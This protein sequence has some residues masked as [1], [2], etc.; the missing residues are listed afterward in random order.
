MNLSFGVGTSQ[1]RVMSFYFYAQCSGAASR[2]HRWTEGLPELFSDLDSVWIS[3][4]ARKGYILVIIQEPLPEARARYNPTLMAI[5]SF[6]L[7]S[8]SPRA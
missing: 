5:G 7:A 3:E 1:L 2:R 4:P 8:R 6:R